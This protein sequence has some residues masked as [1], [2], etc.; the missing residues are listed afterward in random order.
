MYSRSDGTA[1][2]PLG[3]VLSR[4]E[5]ENIVYRC[6]AYSRVDAGGRPWL[7]R[8]DSLNGADASRIR[9]GAKLWALAGRLHPAPDEWP[10]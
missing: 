5:L 10:S 9:Q 7:R 3:Y 8:E 1:P 4:A 6:Y 2:D